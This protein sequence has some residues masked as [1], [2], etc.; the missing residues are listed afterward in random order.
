VA[1]F[2]TGDVVQLKSG[3]PSLTVLEVKGEAVTCIWFDSTLH[4]QQATFGGE[5]LT[6]PVR[7]PAAGTPARAPAGP[8][9]KPA[10]R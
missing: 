6:E 5:L 9:R 7:K 3:G 1:D 8:G 4:V 10:A 2:R